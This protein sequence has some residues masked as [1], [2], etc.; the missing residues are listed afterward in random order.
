[1]KPKGAGQDL[2]NRNRE[3]ARNGKVMCQC[4]CARTF[5]LIPLDDVGT[6]TISCGGRGCNE[7]RTTDPGP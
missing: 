2:V 5:V 3:A 6:R 1:M 7:Q 4:W